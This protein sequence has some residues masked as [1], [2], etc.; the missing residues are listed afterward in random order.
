VQGGFLMAWLRTKRGV[1]V[2]LALFALA[3]QL[4]FSFGH[5][6]IGKA[7]PSLGAPAA[8]A[9]TDAAAGGPSPAKDPADPAGR[10]D[11]FCA[12]CANISLA[13]TLILPILAAILLMLGPFSNV[14]QQL[15]PAHEP[16][17]FRHRPFGARGP[18]VA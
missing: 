9:A 12:V 3:C 4:A 16:A 7:F 1:A 6:H 15:V 10:A 8:A 11:D 18:P 13:S 5:V 2:W 17:S 14:L